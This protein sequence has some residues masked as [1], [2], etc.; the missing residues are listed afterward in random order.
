ML[1]WIGNLFIVVGLWKVGNRVRH[2]FI[3]SGVGELFWIANAH[4]RRDW[5]LASICTIFFLMAIR[6]WV[7]WGKA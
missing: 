2:G 4:I 6:G 5:A 1:G 7:K 3:A